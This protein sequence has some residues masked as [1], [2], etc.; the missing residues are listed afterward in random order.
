MLPHGQRRHRPFLDSSKRPH[1]L[2]RWRLCWWRRTRLLRRAASSGVPSSG[3][4]IPPMRA[5]GPPHPPRGRR[6]RR[7]ARWRR[8]I[9]LS[10]PRQPLLLPLVQYARAITNCGGRARLLGVRCVLRADF[11]I[12]CLTLANARSTKSLVCT[13][14]FSLVLTTSARLLGARQ[15][16]VTG[17]RGTTKSASAH[18]TSRP[19]W[20]RIT[21]RRGCKLRSCRHLPRRP[22]LCRVHLRVH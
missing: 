4:M 15:W 1:R 16:Q 19:T 5:L 22:R 17:R 18:S 6:L 14:A 11:G 7:Y 9:I 13:N 20:S 2:C 10:P 3:F 21:R 8:L 12:R